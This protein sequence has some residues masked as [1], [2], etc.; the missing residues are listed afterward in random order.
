MQLDVLAEYRAWALDSR[1]DK[2]QTCPGCD[3]YVSNC[4]GCHAMTCSCGTS[5]CWLC[6]KI[7][8]RA[9]DDALHKANT[10]SLTHD[11]FRSDE[12]LGSPQAVQQRVLD[13]AT[14]ACRGKLFSLDFGRGEVSAADVEQSFDA[15]HRRKCGGLPAPP[16][17]VAEAVEAV[18]AAL[19]ERRRDDE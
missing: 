13:T 14:R 18:K 10:S 11:H 12:I 4:G 15:M 6:R 16:Q 2:V 8:V 9:D 5:F 7:V 3:V 17:L 19:N 1:P